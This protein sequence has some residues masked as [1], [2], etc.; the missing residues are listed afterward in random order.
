MF[1]F[2]FFSSY[3]FF[4]WTVEGVEAVECSIEPKNNEGRL[5]Q[6]LFCEYDRENRPTLTDRPIT[7]RI[8][9]IVKGFTFADEQGTLSMA[10]WLAMV[11]VRVLGFAMFSV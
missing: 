3:S 7:I 11:C 8:K 10:T 1:F 6:K 4:L 5:R 2:V 9:M